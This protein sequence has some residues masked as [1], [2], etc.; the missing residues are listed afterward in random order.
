MEV[1]KWELWQA[2]DGLCDHCGVWMESTDLACH[3]HHGLVY[4]SDL[5]RSKQPGIVSG[6]V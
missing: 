2:R 6:R 3:I 1:I 5:P 4:K